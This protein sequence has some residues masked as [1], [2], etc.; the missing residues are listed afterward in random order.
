MNLYRLCILFIIVVGG[1]SV[2]PAVLAGQPYS[3]HV[4]TYVIIVPPSVAP[5]PGHAYPPPA[6]GYGHAARG[7]AYGWFGAQS[8]QHWSRHHG[9]YGIYTQWTAR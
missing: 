6:Y 7:Y 8:R 9:Y 2:G 3:G 5:H 1:G 4:P